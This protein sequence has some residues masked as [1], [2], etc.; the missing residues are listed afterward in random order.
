ME[1]WLLT[2]AD[3]ITLLLALF[4]ILYAVSVVNKSKLQAMQQSVNRSLHSAG[5]SANAP[6][7]TVPAPPVSAAVPVTTRPPAPVAPK[8]SDLAQIEAQIRAALAAKGLLGDVTLN[9]APNDLVIQLLADKLYF[10]SDSAALSPA[11]VAVVDTSGAVIAA[12]GNAVNVEGYTDDVPVVGPPFYSNW[13]LSAARA[14]TVVLEMIH[15]DGLKP[16]RVVAEGFG[17]AHPIF[18]NTSP[19][20]MAQNRRVNIVVQA[21]SG[22]NR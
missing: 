10:A 14:V 11:G 22:V 18:P 12:H 21:T 17:D 7:S 20:N 1:R 19:A 16:E 13:E 2:Y 9:L 3:M 8:L 5:L 4:V 15:A 6:P